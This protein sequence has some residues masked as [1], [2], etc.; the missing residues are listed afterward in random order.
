MTLSC[1]PLFP[2]FFLG[3]CIFANRL[4]KEVISLNN[5]FFVKFRPFLCIFKAIFYCSFIYFG[6][7]GN[8]PMPSATI[9]VIVSYI[10]FPRGLIH[11]FSYLLSEFKI[12]NIE[13]ACIWKRGPKGY[14]LPIANR[15]MLAIC[16]HIPS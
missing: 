15:K 5:K 13:H 1:E 11:F 7:R 9:L 16:L 12:S 4:K 3:I 2:H 8:V 14:S 6:V 10:N